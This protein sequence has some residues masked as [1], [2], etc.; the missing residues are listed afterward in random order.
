MVPP[1]AGNCPHT[2]RTRRLTTSRTPTQATCPLSATPSLS[3]GAVLG[4]GPGG[5][6][7][8]SAWEAP[9][10]EGITPAGRPEGRLGQ[11]PD[12]RPHGTL[13]VEHVQAASLRGRPRTETALP[14]PRFCALAARVKVKGKIRASRG[15]HSIPLQDISC[16]ALTNGG[17]LFRECVWGGDGHKHVFG[18]LLH[19]NENKCDLSTKNPKLI[20]S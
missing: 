12:P 16:R 2:Q 7:G 20:G 1:R 6:P 13:R 10:V 11:E 18:S 8:L 5:G 17:S 3:L 19:H 15:A 4:G 9:W 14:S